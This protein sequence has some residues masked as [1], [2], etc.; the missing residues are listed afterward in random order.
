MLTKEAFNA[1]LKTLEEPPP[2]VK[3]FF[4]TTEPHKVLS[5]ILSRCQRFDLT[6]IADD[7]LAACLKDIAGKMGADISDD[8][9]LELVRLSDG[10][11]RDGQSLLEQVLLSSDG[12][13]NAEA[14]A[15]CL[16]LLTTTELSALD[17]AIH[18]SDLAFAFTLSEKLFLSGKDLAHFLTSLSDHMRTLL[19]AKMG[20]HPHLKAAS[21]PYTKEHLLYILD[22]LAKWLSEMEKNSFKRLHIEM[23]L[24]HLIRSKKR[25]TIEGLFDRLTALENQETPSRRID[26]RP[27]LPPPKPLPPPPPE[28]PPAPPPSPEPTPAPPPQ[29]K[30]ADKETLLRFAGV[31]LNGSVKK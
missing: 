23:I 16:G 5:T 21:E 1:L 9:L 15:K 6:R 14:V 13:I 3:F 31:E 20:L 2:T 29:D 10:S 17:Q 22:Y 12:A 25:L 27:P 19:L 24:L 28:T 7:K 26:P 11:L 4:A 18:S 30:S 8:G